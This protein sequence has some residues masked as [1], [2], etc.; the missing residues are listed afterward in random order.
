MKKETKRFLAIFFIVAIL[1]TMIFL[2]GALIIKPERTK[3]EQD[4][5]YMQITPISGGML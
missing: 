2:A 5:A 4:R 1:A 3:Y